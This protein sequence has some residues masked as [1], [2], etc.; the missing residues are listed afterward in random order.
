MRCPSHWFLLFLL[1]HYNLELHHLTPLGVLHIAAFVTLCEAHL[2]IDLEFDLWNY[3]FCVRRPQDPEAELIISEGAIIHVKLGAWGRS[4]PQPRSM[5]GWRKKWIYLR[6]D[7]SAPLP[8]FT[9]SRPVPMPSLG[10]D[11]VEK[12]LNKLQSLCK[13]L[14]QLR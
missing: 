11:L 6:N 12:D 7:A 2:G 5:K 10:D 13:T 4:L 3:F 14:Q 9:S 8:T 1:R